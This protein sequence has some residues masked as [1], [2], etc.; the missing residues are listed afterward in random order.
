MDCVTCE[1]CK[2][3]SKL[4]LL[5]IATALK[6]LLNNG[7]TSGNFTLKR[8]EIIALFNTLQKFSD[9]IDAISMMREQT[10]QQLKEEEHRKESGLSTTIIGSLFTVLVLVLCLGWYVWSM[11][12]KTRTLHV[13][14]QP[15]QTVRTTKPKKDQ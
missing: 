6:I 10:I 12:Q 1:T 4:Q 5:G 2:V 13:P 14:H 9:S 7:N 3:H 11:I 15:T 8:N